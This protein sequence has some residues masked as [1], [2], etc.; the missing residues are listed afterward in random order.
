MTGWK[1]LYVGVKEGYKGFTEKELRKE[2]HTDEV[3]WRGTTKEGGQKI[4]EKFT[5]FGGGALSQ[6]C[7]GTGC[8]AIFLKVSV[9]QQSL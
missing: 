8:N 9:H 3:A 2:A 5:S 1:A 6:A 7:T 4:G